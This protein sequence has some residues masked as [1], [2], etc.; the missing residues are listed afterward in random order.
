MSNTEG[1]RIGANRQL[2]TPMDELRASDFITGLLS[3]ANSYVSGITVLSGITSNIVTIRPLQAHLHNRE[4][5]HMTIVFRDGS[6]S[7]NI[8]MGPY[9]LNPTQER[10]IN[11]EQLR[12][13]RFTSGIYAM[14]ISGTFSTGIDYQMGY[15]VE[16]DPTDPGGLLE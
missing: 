16:P 1:R 11:Q 3:G 10:D 2:V 5:S 15:L 13:R 12:G 14:V 6:I 7:G 9:I 4:T 8:V